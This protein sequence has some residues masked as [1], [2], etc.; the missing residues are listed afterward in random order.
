M[1]DFTFTPQIEILPVEDA[2][3]CQHWSDADKI[4]LVEESYRGQRAA[5]IYTLIGTA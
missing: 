4:R 5:A 2:P 3:R 1:A